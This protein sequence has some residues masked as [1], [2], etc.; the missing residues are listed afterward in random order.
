MK[1]KIVIVVGV[2]LVVLSIVLMVSNSQTS[3]QHNHH[4]TEEP[5]VSNSSTHADI[6]AFQSASA[7]KDL[8]PTLAP[9]EFFGKAREA[10][11]AAKVIPETLAQLP[12]YCHCDRGFG[13]KSLH[14]CFQDDHASHCAVCVDEALMAYKLQKEDKLPPE[15]IRELIIAKYAAE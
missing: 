8:P 15:K 4:S 12:C 9:A 3:T 6:P 2:V 7:A 1:S 11:A 14:T 5:I 13:H 10:Y